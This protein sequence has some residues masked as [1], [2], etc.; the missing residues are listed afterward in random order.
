MKTEEQF[1]KDLYSGQL[2]SQKN[3]YQDNYQQGKQN[4]DQQ[5]QQVQEQTRDYQVRTEV[6]AQQ[7]QA[8]QKQNAAL[9]AGGQAQAALSQKNTQQKNTTALDAQRQQAEQEIERQRNLLG[10]QYAAAIQQAQARNDMEQAQALYD[11]AKQEEQNFISMRQKAG[12]L[13]AT[14]GDYSILNGLYGI[15]G[16]QMPQGGA[17]PQSGALTVDEE[18]YLRQ[19]YDA[20]Q[21]GEEAALRA[22]Y[23]E[24]ASD[25]EAQRI[26]RQR[27]TDEALNKTYT[28]SARAARNYNEMAAAYGMGSG[29]MAQAQIARGNELTEDLTDL[30]RQQLGADAS[31][32]AQGGAYYRELMDSIAKRQ[33]EN[34]SAFAE[35]LY[36]ARKADAQQNLE[37]QLQAAN[38]RAQQGDYSL[39]GQLYG[40]TPEQIARLEGRGGNP[41]PRPQQPEVPEQVTNPNM[42][43]NDGSGADLYYAN[44]TP[45]RGKSVGGNSGSGAN[46][47][48][49]LDMASVEAL[50]LGGL[51]PQEVADMVNSGV[52]KQTLKGNKIV[53]EVND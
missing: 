41:N 28:D 4:L 9:S 26:A 45:V 43:G 30:R 15:G 5:G 51:S 10:Q 50:G 2:D 1:I 25:L 31:L 38:L 6:E 7:A 32:Q 39:L 33:Q 44:P 42:G 12:E 8:Q 52:L 24:A 16:E 47:A 46:V 13:M 23:D 27:Q 11:Q 53:L 29:T 48:T 22:E 18:N 3:Q 49:S 21:Q 20:K 17:I 37:L 19:I 34:D 40:L 36:N 14:K 35:D